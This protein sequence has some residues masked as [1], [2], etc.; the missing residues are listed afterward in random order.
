MNVVAVFNQKGGVGKTTI[1][2]N[3]AVMLAGLGYRTVFIDL[4]FQGDGTSQLWR[5]DGPDLTVYDLLARRCCAEEAAVAADFPNLSVVASSRKLSLIEAGADA[6][7]WRQTELKANGF[8]RSP[9]DFLLV[10]CPPAL[11]RLAANALTAA[12]FLI[13]PVTPTSFAI[14]GMKR[15]LEIHS[16]VRAGLNPDLRHYRVCLSMVDDK[17][18]SRLLA[19]EIVSA[20]GASLFKTGVPFDSDVHKAATYKTPAVL[21]N[22]DSNFTTSLAALA[23]DVIETLGL[24]LADNAVEVMRERLYAKHHALAANFKDIAELNV[25]CAERLAAS[26]PSVP[27]PNGGAINGSAHKRPRPIASRLKP[28]LVG[29][30]IGAAVGFFAGAHM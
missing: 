13:V 28:F 17:P 29:S 14:E 7:G 20:Q 6:A 27:G 2:V 16:A 5:G 9:P 11:G 8:T 12:N 3:L 30:I 15:T 1:S 25:E 22:P 23:V 19:A 10:D 24:E 21:Y 18:V 4:D 26:A